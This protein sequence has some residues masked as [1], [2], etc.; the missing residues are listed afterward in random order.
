M[1]ADVVIIGGGL[2]GLECAALLSRRGRSVVVV[3]QGSRPGGSIQ[4][5]R[6]H[7]RLMDTG[8]H[9]VGGIAEGQSLH[10]AFSA[11]GL[12]SLPWQRMRTD[13]F[14]RV[15]IDGQSYDFCEGFDNFARRITDYFPDEKAAISYFAELL[16][17]VCGG[18]TEQQ[19]TINKLAQI[20]AWDYLSAHF[21]NQRLIDVLSGTAL[22]MEL[23]RQSLPLFNFAHTLG[24]YIESS[25]KLRGGGVQIVDCLTRSITDNGG[26]IVCSSRVARLAVKDGRV[27]AAIST[28]GEAFE[29]ATF[30]SDIHP[31]LT[32][33]LIDE[34]LLRRSYR[35]R[36]VRAENTFG[37]FTASLTF[38]PQT[39]P[40][41]GRNEFVYSRGDVWTVHERSQRGSCVMISQSVPDDGSEFT[42]GIDLL[43]PMA[44]SEVE[45]WLG[46]GPMR[47]GDDYKELKQRWAEALI[48]LAAS[49]MPEIKDYNGICTST[50]L[51]WHDYTLAPQ[52]TAYGMRKDAASP[53]TSLMSV[54]TPL[55]NL[56]LTGQNL[57]LH[58]IQGVTMTALITCK[59]IMKLEDGARWS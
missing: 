16:R 28:D 21:R 6:R 29:A 31:T 42:T 50:P 58:G 38:K 1:K 19:E 46:T 25:W 47:R 33:G 40:Y 4:C 44:W 15:T 22:K 36:L 2:G 49:R 27:R 9:Y 43:A 10:E 48:D 14:D 32:I 34:T 51:T 54:R 39:V 7:G 30:I 17:S 12:L 37:M 18:G 53:L 56:L 45:K 26:R 41:T 59:E 57:M 23:R 3:E 11:F 13:G 5:Y 8:F 35:N 55:P 52:G 20:N 24:G